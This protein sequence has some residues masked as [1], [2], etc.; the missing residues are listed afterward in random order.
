MY[1]SLSRARALSLSHVLSFMYTQCMYS[2]VFIQIPTMTLDEAFECKEQMA[3][4]VKD[5]VANSMKGFGL[6]VV[7]ALLTDMQVLT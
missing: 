4:T 2:I 3:T 1:L 5:Q 7:K 6:L